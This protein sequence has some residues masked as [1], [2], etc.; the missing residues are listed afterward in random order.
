MR[1][2]CLWHGFWLWSVDY[3]SAGYCHC[4][5]SRP[6]TYCVRLCEKQEH[7]PST[8]TTQF[9]QRVTTAGTATISLR[10]WQYTVNSEK[11]FH[12][13]W[14]R[15]WVW[16]KGT[17]TATSPT[18]SFLTL[19]TLPSG[20]MMAMAEDVCAA[21]VDAGF[22]TLTL[23]MGHRLLNVAGRMNVQ[24]VV[25]DVR[26][27]GKSVLNDALSVDQLGQV[28]VFQ[29]H[30][31]RRPRFLALKQLWV[32]T[33]LQKII[34]GLS[35][36]SQPQDVASRKWCQVHVIHSAPGTHQEWKLRLKKAEIVQR[37]GWDGVWIHLIPCNY[38]IGDFELVA[39]FE[40]HIYTNAFSLCFLRYD[41]LYYYH[42]IH[43]H[44]PP[45]FFF[46]FLSMKDFF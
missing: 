36:H 15:V 39:H 19:T 30:V 9:R 21:S 33:H 32:V 43:P 23:V 28:V 37:R 45:H 24:L 14:Q 11:R 27:A 44:R 26:F 6:S 2:W 35:V 31:V 5:V 13:G 20:V 8:P 29:K 42:F 22:V 12:E 38:E 1:S 46:F 16:A 10:Y 18:T 3:V 40:Q 25:V 7:S 17:S 4:Q 41:F 34:I